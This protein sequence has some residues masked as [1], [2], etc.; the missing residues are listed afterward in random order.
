MTDHSVDVL[1]DL[2]TKGVLDLD[3]NRLTRNVTTRPYRAPEVAL[4]TPYDAKIDVWA[5]GCIFAELLLTSLSGKRELLFQAHTCQPL[6]PLPEN[7]LKAQRPKEYYL[8]NH[9]DL[10]VL[11][12]KFFRSFRPETDLSFLAIH[13]QKEYMLKLCSLP[14]EYAKQLPTLS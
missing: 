8:M 13:L 7:L 9:P 14:I 5:A 3:S 11:H 1:N 2:F 12:A 10:L 4:L 6:S